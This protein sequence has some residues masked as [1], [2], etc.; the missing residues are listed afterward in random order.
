MTLQATYPQV[1]L[2]F[3]APA[4]LDSLAPLE[5]IDPSSGIRAAVVERYAVD[6]LPV[7]WGAACGFYI[8]F[9]ALS[10]GNQ[11]ES[12]VGKATSGFYRR[13]ASHDETKDYWQSALLV[14]KEGSDPFQPVQLAWLENRMRGI[15]D[16]SANVNVRNIPQT[17]EISLPEQEEGDMEKVLLSTLRVMFLRGYRN[18]SMGEFADELTA[19]ITAQADNYT[20]EKPTPVAQKIAKPALPAT[21]PVVSSPLSNPQTSSEDDK[22][23]ALKEWRNFESKRLS[24][25]PFIIFHDKALR[26]ISRIAPTTVDELA[27]IP[28][29]GRDKAALYGKRLVTLFVTE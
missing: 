27:A 19:R 16:L 1:R 20:A 10:S 29:V 22:F 8:L 9:S 2:T 15:L 21:P 11:F 5:I 23:F 18:A 4:S 28:G 6:T 7:Q 12:Y 25:S 3:L 17:G 14:T 24:I 13:L 26:E